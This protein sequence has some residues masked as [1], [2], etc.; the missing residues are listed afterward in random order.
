VC[1]ELFYMHRCYQLSLFF[2]SAY[3]LIEFSL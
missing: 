3:V 1:H 2:F